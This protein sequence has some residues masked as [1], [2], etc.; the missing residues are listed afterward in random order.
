MPV[1]SSV[2]L[3]ANTRSLSRR[4]RPLWVRAG[5]QLRLRRSSAPA[6]S[7]R[8]KLPPAL[9]HAGNVMLDTTPGVAVGQDVGDSARFAPEELHLRGACLD[10]PCGRLPWRGNAHGA[11]VVLKAQNRAPPLTLLRPNSN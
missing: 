11:G 3:G 10:A 9:A 1:S 2:V 6:P 5:G 4:C 7:A 8:S